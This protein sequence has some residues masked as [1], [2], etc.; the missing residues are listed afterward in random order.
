[1]LRHRRLVHSPTPTRLTSTLAW[2]PPMSNHAGA[3]V[4]LLAGE[5]VRLGRV[6]R[7][8]SRRVSLPAIIFGPDGY[9]RRLPLAV[10]ALTAG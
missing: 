2:H 1:M 5:L 4:H 8:S 9:H 3:R 7:D 6:Y 10:P